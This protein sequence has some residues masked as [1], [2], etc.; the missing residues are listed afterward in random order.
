MNKF[1]VCV[2]WSKSCAELNT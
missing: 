1:I 2:G